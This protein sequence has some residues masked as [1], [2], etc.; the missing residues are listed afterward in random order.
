VRFIVEHADRVTVDGLRWGVEPICA[1]LTEHGTPIAPSTYYEH[2][3]A[4]A[5]AARTDRQARADWLDAAVAR[6]YA[7]NYDAYGARKVWSQPRWEGI[8]VARCS[9][10]TSVRRQGIQGLRR[11]KAK[12]TTIADP[13]AP[14]PGDLVARQF[15]PEAPDRLWVADFTYVST[16][17]GWVYVVFVIDAYARRNLGWRCSHSMTTPL[18]LDAIE[19]A[20]WTRERDGVTDLTGLIHHN[21]R[22]SQGGFNRSSKHRLFGVIVGARR[23]P[24]RGSSIRGSCAVGY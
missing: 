24:R 21:D 13:Q 4:P 1:A 12:R 22:G 23:E 6:V 16:W 18:V 5:T 3:A 2:R 7:A 19:Q 10:E 8:D 17:S 9:V 14:R 11:G 20:I 15:N